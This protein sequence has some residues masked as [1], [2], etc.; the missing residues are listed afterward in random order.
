MMLMPTSFL[1]LV[2]L[3]RLSV[4]ML[5]LMASVISVVLMTTLVHHVLIISCMVM[6]VLIMVGEQLFRVLNF[7]SVAHVFIVPFIMSYLVDECE[8]GSVQLEDRGS[9]YLNN[10]T[11]FY[12]GRPSVCINSSY[13]PYCT[14][15]DLNTARAFCGKG[16]KYYG[17]FFSYNWSN[18]PF[19]PW[20]I[21]H[22]HQKI[23]S[24]RIGSK[25]S[26]K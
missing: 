3:M 16:F 10:G 7:V 2:L 15:F 14:L 4:M 5:A 13:V 8:T 21:V 11:R 12:I 17:K 25:K 9:G 20:T 18:F 6:V 24:F 26:C 23:Q 19:R 1:S 22:G